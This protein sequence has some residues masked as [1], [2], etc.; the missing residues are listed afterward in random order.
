MYLTYEEYSN[1]G[2]TVEETAFTHIEFNAR[3]LI[4]KH[5]FNRVAAG[6]AKGKFGGDEIEC[7]KHCVFELCNLNEQDI[8]NG[9]S[10]VISS[11]SNDGV[12]ESYVV[13]TSA[14]DIQ[15][16][17]VRILTHYL[18]LVTLDGVPVLYRGADVLPSLVERNDYSL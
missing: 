10:K 14:R 7:I 16:Q 8:F 11:T 15:A 9:N 6:L 1:M 3:K 18:S 12:S 4:D 5:T 13:P 17:E 2:G